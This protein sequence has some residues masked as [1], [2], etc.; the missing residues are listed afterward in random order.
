MDSLLANTFNQ[1][2]MTIDSNLT[3]LLNTFLSNS[4]T[5]EL[6]GSFQSEAITSGGLLKVVSNSF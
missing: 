5:E 6:V 3:G 1:F 2:K 4:T